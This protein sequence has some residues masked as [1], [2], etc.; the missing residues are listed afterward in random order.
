MNDT[1]DE[2][3]FH[4]EE[5]S[6][7]L[8]L[9]TAL[10]IG[11]GTMIAAGIF[12]L[13]GLAIRNVGSAAILSFLLAALVALFTALT[14]CEFVSI[15]PRSGEGYLYARKTYPAP[16]A[17][18]VGWALFLGY[19]SSCAFYIAS[20]SS[21]F[22][23]FLWHSPIEQLSGIV[24]LIA[25]TMLNIKG[26]K[27]SGSFQVIVTVVKVLLLLWFVIGGLSYVNPEEVIAKFSTDVVQIVSTSALVFITFFGFSAI[28]ASAGEVK[29][30]V[31]NIPRAIFLS[32]GI[33]TVLYTLVVLVILAANLTEYNE[34]AMGVA[35]KMFLGGVGGMVIIAGGLFSMIS[36][37]NASIMAGSRVALAMSQLGHFP[38]E[39]GTI[40]P[41]TR[42]PIISTFLVAGSILIFV[43]LLPL[44]DLAHF[45]D[46]VLLL[47]LILVNAALIIHRKK[48]PNIERPFKVPLVPILPGLGILF[49]LYL[50]SQI[51]HHPLPVALAFGALA[52]GMV[53]FLMWK[54]TQS[55]AEA[56]PGEASRVAAGRY[57]LS[58]DEKETFRVLVPIANPATLDNLMK[59]AAAIAK[60]KGGEVVALRVVNVPEQTPVRGNHR[61]LVEAEQELL[62]RAD[63]SGENYGVPVTS[64]VCISHSTARA[65]LEISRRRA[66]DLIV[67]GWKGYS[68]RGEK[69]LGEITDAVVTHARTDLMLV[70]IPNTGL[71][72]QNIL[73]PTAGGEHARAAEQYA[74]SIGRTFE[75]GSVTVCSVQAKDTNAERIK[76]IT[77]QL[78]EAVLRVSTKNGVQVTSKIIEHSD[79]TKGVIEEGKNYDAI[80]VGATRDSIYPQILFGSIPEN[81]AKG[82]ENTVIMVK[83]YHPVKALLGRVIGE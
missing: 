56:L 38:K 55:E 45:A 80:M 67:M 76:E 41:K 42:T 4:E 6:R 61:R 22:N 5:L 11:V 81:I 43:L 3:S 20:L 19:A 63:Q 64:L 46:T 7:D 12:T 34:A 1:I 14:Y 83:H 68:T 49:N 27:E 71:Q 16:L 82:S 62:D 30:P 28:A 69:M 60:E 17:Y 36:A 70:K 48:F 58:A 32:M 65:I 26:T 10:A 54:G 79:I 52:L 57:S 2:Q 66:C 77:M 78:G 25:L 23:E 39:F 47:V 9:T 74:A 31:K 50:L 15:Y 21:Y 51:F 53:G 73:L 75:N 18:F 8:G 33:V 29:D 59:L 37:S 44:E 72:L 24:A 35:A 13:S 40:N